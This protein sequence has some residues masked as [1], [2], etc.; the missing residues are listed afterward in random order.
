MQYS[1]KNLQFALTIEPGN[2]K[3]QQKLTWAQNQRQAGQPTIPSTI[4][5]EL[6][7]N[8]FMRIDLPEI[9]VC[10]LSNPLKSVKQIDNFLSMGRRNKVDTLVMP[11]VVLVLYINKILTYLIRKG[12]CNLC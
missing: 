10:H 9:Q 8:P 3:T 4:E 11:S 5:E 6:E 7:T 2:L 12:T 1:V